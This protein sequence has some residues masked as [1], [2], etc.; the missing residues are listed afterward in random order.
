HAGPVKALTFAPLRQGKPLLLVSAAEE[1]ER[2][3][4]APVDVV[5]VWDADQGVPVHELRGFKAPS[6]RAGLVVWHTG[7]DLKHV[8]IAL[9]CNEPRLRVW[10]LARASAEPPWTAETVG[11]TFLATAGVSGR[12]QLLTLQRHK[13]EA[14]LGVWSVTPGENPVPQAPLVFPQPDSGA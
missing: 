3:A 13:G 4:A 14:Q 1:W 6:W 2:G 8:Q 11:G 7:A 10:D 12:G 9:T 5:R